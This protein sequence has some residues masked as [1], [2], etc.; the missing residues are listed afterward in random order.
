VFAGDTAIDCSAAAAVVSALAELFAPS[1][2]VVG[3]AT[4]AVLAITVP[5]GVV[6][7]SFTT[8]ARLTVAP[9]A[10]EPRLHV[11]VLVP[12]HDPADGVADT[13]EVWAGTTSV[14]VTPGASDGPLF[15]TPMA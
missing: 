8:S 9:L 13:N 3:D 6:G 15:V 10:I 7:S 1:G 12:A 5:P 4:E 2:S 14:A 11:T